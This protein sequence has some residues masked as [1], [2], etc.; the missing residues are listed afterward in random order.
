MNDFDIIKMPI[1]LCLH[2]RQAVVGLDP[3]WRLCG[4]VFVL[5]NRKQC[6]FLV[7]K[8]IFARVEGT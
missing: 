3:K 1:F 8:R 4:T 7:Y 5:N 6:R 2:N